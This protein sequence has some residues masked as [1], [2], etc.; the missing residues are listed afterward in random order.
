MDV[1]QYSPEGFRGEI[2]GIA[3]L[4]VMHKCLHHFPQ[5]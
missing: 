1:D 2:T 5:L 4:L 3:G